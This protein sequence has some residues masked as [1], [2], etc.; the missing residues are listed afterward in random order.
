MTANNNR[1][2]RRAGIV[3]LVL[4][5]LLCGAWTVLS[6]PASARL[7][8]A[9][10]AG[11]AAGIP[12][13]MAEMRAFLDERFGP[14]VSTEN[15]AP[16][17]VAAAS[18]LG[19]VNFPSR[20]DNRLPPVD[21]ALRAL[22]AQAAPAY[23][24]LEQAAGMPRCRYDTR[25]ED[26]IAARMPEIMKSM[27]L[28]GALEARAAVR[29][30]DGDALGVLDD[31]HLIAALG[32][33]FEEHPTLIA[34]LIRIA[35]V[36]AADT[37][38]RDALPAQRE[39]FE[40]WAATRAWRIRGAIVYGF[41]GEFAFASSAVATASADEMAPLE[42]PALPRWASLAWQLQR[43]QAVQVLDTYRGLV[44]RE[45]DG[46]PSLLAYA[47]DRDR[48][49]QES[50][51]LGSVLSVAVHGMIEKEAN[52]VTQ[53]AVTE[54]GA[55]LLTFQRLHDGRIPSQL[56]EVPG[57]PTDPRT[58]QPLVLRVDGERVL[59]AADDGVGEWEVPPPR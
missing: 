45:S 43:G 33:S 51:M 46:Y 21:D 13:H 38:L 1:R 36:S 59:I 11:R 42:G 26:G 48:E 4:V 55:R 52:S 47:D 2:L 6:I 44:E 22:V 16:L 41:H 20:E 57:V 27:K 3:A 53:R 30:A 28:R 58:G 31:A 19:D 24:L 40:A 23:E 18:H 15:A 34:Q 7:S 8:A 37:L 50:G 49:S 56:D 29:L 35:H 54:A 32:A 17:Y 5:V 12:V 25:W 39:P 14:V 9:I 10:E